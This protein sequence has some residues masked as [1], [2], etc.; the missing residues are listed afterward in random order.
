VRLSEVIAAA[1]GSIA[2]ID[3]N[4]V[5]VGR[6]GEGV[7]IADALIERQQRSGGVRESD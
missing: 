3:M 2:S 7:V 1:Q 4:P 5:M 6:Q